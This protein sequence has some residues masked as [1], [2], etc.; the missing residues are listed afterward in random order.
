MPI[1]GTVMAVTA[2]SIG[3]Q[4]FNSLLE[5][6]AGLART[7]G[8]YALGARPGALGIDTVSTLAAGEYF[9]GMGPESVSRFRGLT[10]EQQGQYGQIAS[11]L[12]GQKS[13]FGWR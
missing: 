12:L 5:Q 10:M 9:P 8:L 13:D 11:T 7:S 3:L 6:N 1:M 2:A 4:K